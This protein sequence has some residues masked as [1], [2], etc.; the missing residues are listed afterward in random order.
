MFFVL[1]MMMMMMT[2]MMMT[3]MTP[4]DVFSWIVEQDLQPEQV[5]HL[6]LFRGLLGILGDFLLTE[7]L[8][9]GRIGWVFLQA[10]TGIA[11]SG[12]MRSL[13]TLA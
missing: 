11:P 2:M 8:K 5:S 4:N 1:M 7:I 13:D 9:A 6:A 3:M 12:G 10:G